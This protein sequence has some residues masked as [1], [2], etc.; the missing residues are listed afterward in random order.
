MRPLFF[1]LTPIVLQAAELPLP[2]RYVD[3]MIGTA[4]HGHVFPGAT[5][6][7]GM[8]QASPDTGV[9]GWDRCSGY[10][11]DDPGILGFSH[12]HLSGTGCGD[13][14]NLLFMPMQGEVR[15][16]PTPTGVGGGLR[17]DTGARVRFSHDQEESEVGYYR[18]TFD[19]P[20]IQV[21]LTATE[22]CAVH[23][24]TFPEKGDAS[25]LI[26]LNHKI[27]PP[28]EPAFE[29]ELKVIDDHTVV[30]WQKTDGWSNPKTYSFVAEFSQP[31]V[32]QELREG[33]N[34]KSGKSLKGKAIKGAFHFD[35]D[36]SKP[37]VVKVGVS[38]IDISGAKKNL[39]KE[40][41][42]ADFEAVRKGTVEKWNA[43]L[44]KIKVDSSDPAWLSTF[45]TALYRTM[46]APNLYNDADGHWIGPDREVQ[47][48][49]GFDH[50]STFSLWDTF[51]AANP[52]YTLI[53]PDRVDDFTSGMLAHYK[54]SPWK[55]LPVW[56]LCGNDTWCMIGY[57]SIPVIVDAYFKGLTDFN[58]RDM[59][60][61][62]VD[63]SNRRE[64]N[65]EYRENGWAPSGDDGAQGTS[66]TL[67]YAFDDW[68]I[69]R[70]A[71]AIGDKKV[72][73][74]Y[75]KRAQN[76]RNVFDTESSLMRGKDRNGKWLEPFKP[77]VVDFT[78]F[79]E[80]NAW[81]YTWSVMHDVPGL[82]ELMGGPEKFVAKL[83]E[84]WTIEGVESHA[85]DVTGLIGQYAHGNEPS[86]HAAYLYD[87]AGQPWKTQKW[88]R[89]IST[90]FYT[91]KPDGVCGNEDCGQMSAWYVFSSLGIYPV[92]PAS[93]V[94]MIGSPLFRRAQ[95]ELKGGKTFEVI[96]KDN[97]PD[98][99]YIQEA[100]LN[101]K[102]LDRAWITHREL[103]AGGTLAFRMGSE[104]NKAWAVK[105][106]PPV[107]GY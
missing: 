66:R 7:F 103:M 1:V 10:H 36:P 73:R 5:A 82:I 19:D 39:A 63:S 4:G 65:R 51:R 101:G 47:S 107:S 95:V 88:I 16:D 55:Q 85:P 12:T 76:Y 60:A 41:G 29:A 59:L 2:A 98:S 8:V 68:C 6:P 80:A 78:S 91:D 90:Q 18:V 37:L 56:T 106:L 67:E 57:H 17:P 35:V 53:V 52:L 34:E 105:E 93:G 50:Y 87:F 54:H 31:I 32:S 27:S 79:T 38:P 48:K 61:A 81:Q 25:V 96:A 49:S 23:R 104:P 26:D 21:E 58:E 42:D 15:W 43:L 3:P 62:M 9:H 100:L 11:Y 69:A 44:G 46:V 45:Y 64:W 75:D 20:K 84:M 13:L 92:N 71:E 99:P 72:T 97:G 77:T 83:D 74:E 14:G 94:Y 86:H 40:V 28:G 22:R 30:G 70:F 102:P 24:Y 89:D 33:G